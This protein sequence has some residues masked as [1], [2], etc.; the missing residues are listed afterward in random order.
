MVSEVCSWNEWD[1]LEEVLVGTARGAADI[2]YEPG[3]AGYFPDGGA[4][5]GFRGAPVA[6]ALIDEAERQLDGLA[7]VMA[8]RGIKVRRPEPMDHGAPVRGEDWEVPAGRAAACPRDALLVVGDQI[9]EAPMPLRARST[10][11]RAYRPLL[12]H[13]AA[14][15]ARV[16][17]APM[18]MLRDTLYLP[19]SP[20]LAEDEPVFDAACFARCGRDIFWQ[21]DM[22]SNEAGAAWL[23]DRLGPG[24]RIHRLAFREA[25][26]MHIDTT[27]VPIRPGL[28][29]INPDRPCVAGDI[30]LF[31]ANGWQLLAAPPSVRSG[32]RRPGAVSNWIS[33]NLLMLDPCTAIIERAETPMTGLLETLG[34]RVIPLPFD[35]VYGFGGGFHCCTL[36]LRREG[37]LQSYFPTL[38]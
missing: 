33:M 1:P 22:V 13:Y 27:L 17:R 10:E 34:C 32:A 25:T 15:G 11:A 20:W 30:G 35:R 4:D 38:D 16:T 29:L 8:A 28:A 7:A 23:A 18:P 12:D 36:D 26:P 6:P 3:L 19:T 37:K 21:A 9:I 2:G 24:F 5:R 31:A 14:A